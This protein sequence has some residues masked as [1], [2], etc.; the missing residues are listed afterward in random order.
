[1]Y[2]YGFYRE[3]E[4]TSEDLDY[5]RAERDKAER[6]ATQLEREALE[7][8]RAARAER[9]AWAEDYAALSEDY[10][11]LQ[12]RYSRLEAVLT[13]NG[14]VV[15]ELERMAEFYRGCSRNGE[16]E[17]VQRKAD[18]LRAALDTDDLED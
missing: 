8:K 2:S 17:R 6:Y 7:T 15:A 9:M 1:M 3:T 5:A 13:K 18:A 14:G 12:E 10:D 16:A 4:P 11:A